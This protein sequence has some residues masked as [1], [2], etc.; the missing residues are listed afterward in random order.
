MR[1]VS[2]RSEV[3]VHLYGQEVNPETFAIS[4]ADLI[5]KGCP[6]LFTTHHH[7]NNFPPAW[8]GDCQPGR[9]RPA[10]SLGDGIHGVAMWCCRRVCSN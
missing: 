7:L 6:F 3:S 9:A 10:G 2:P 5:L 1:L 8:L 4:K